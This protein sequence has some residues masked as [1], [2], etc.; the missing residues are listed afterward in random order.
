MDVKEFAITR[1]AKADSR[2]RELVKAVQSVLDKE[3]VDLKQLK[4]SLIDL[5]EY[6]SSEN[7]RTDQNCSAVDNFFIFDDLWV[8]RNLPEPFQ[9]IFGNM[10]GLHDTVSAPEIAGNFS[11]TPE[12]LLERVRQLRTE[13]VNQGKE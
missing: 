2:V 1:L 5:F 4:Q 11:F 3:I 9:D 10:P 12:Q 8:E 7:G 6:L 13:P